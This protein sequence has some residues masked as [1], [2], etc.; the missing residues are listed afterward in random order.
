MD[1]QLLLDHISN[2]IGQLSPSLPRGGNLFFRI[3]RGKPLRPT[4]FSGSNVL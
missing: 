2:R 1:L 4:S 3:P